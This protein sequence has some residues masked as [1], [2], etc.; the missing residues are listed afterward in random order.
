[1]P[2]TNATL[3]TQFAHMD[4]LCTKLCISLWHQNFSNF[5]RTLSN[6]YTS[7]RRGRFYELGACMLHIYIYI[8]IL[9]I[10]KKRKDKPGTFS[11]TVKCDYL[12]KV[13]IN[14]LWNNNPY[15]CHTYIN[16]EIS[17]SI[18]S[19]EAKISYIVEV[20]KIMPPYQ[21]CLATIH[22]F[23]KFYYIYMELSI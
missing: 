22:N 4:E 3:C 20:T 16:A 17:T 6:T 12:V 1:M 23:I 18:A 8:Y 5:S 19:K 9:K 10:W 11:W 21:T 14:V 13:W 7:T 2:Q 15:I